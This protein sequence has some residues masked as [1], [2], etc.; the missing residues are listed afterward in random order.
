MRDISMNTELLEKAGPNFSH[1]AL[2]DA[3]KNTKE[4]LASSIKPSMLEED[5]RQMAKETL[6]CLGS[7]K[8]WHKIL[9]RFGANTVKNFEDPSDRSVRLRDHDIFLSISAPSGPILKAMAVKRSSSAM[10]ISR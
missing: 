1:E 5:V 6:E 4:A 9:I 2:M 3:R 10:A 7:T 8:G